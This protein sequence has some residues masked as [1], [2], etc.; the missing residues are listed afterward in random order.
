MYTVLVFIPLQ[1]NTPRDEFNAQ[2]NTFVLHVCLHIVD[3][4]CC[5]SCYTVG[6]VCLCTYRTHFSQVFSYILQLR[7]KNLW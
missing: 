7:K 5:S 4:F 6:I 2:R 3:I 1:L